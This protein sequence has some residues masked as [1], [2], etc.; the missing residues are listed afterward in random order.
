MPRRPGKKH[1][2]PQS[3]NAAV[4]SICDI[5]RRSNCAGALQYVPELTWI[6]FLRILDEREAR[7]SEEAEALGVPFIPTLIPP[8]R[9]RDWAAPKSPMREDKNASVWKFVHEQLLPEL[10]ALKERP[11][12]PPRQ[13]VVSEI[14]SGVDRSRIDSEKNFLDVLD[15]VHEIS[16][17]TVDETHVFTLSQVYEGL[18]LKMGE[19][20][21]DGGQFFTPR[22][23]IRAMVRVVDPR[24]GKTVYDPGCGTG[25]FLAQSFEY[26]RNKA[27]GKITGPQ[28]EM[29]KHRTFY[30]REKD[31]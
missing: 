24:I 4:K 29:L 23:V 17:V 13:K 19:K 7:E 1:S 31:N 16:S 8:F 27:G 28:L 11:N 14:M 20:G 6:L 18:L 25:G 9:W 2:S 5:M 26:M 10:K 22:E 3:L 12:A 30:G 21:N 15:K